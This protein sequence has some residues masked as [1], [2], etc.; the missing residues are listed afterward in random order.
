MIKRRAIS[1][2]QKQVRRQAMIDEAW[3]LF[4][5]QRYETINMIDV[6]QRVGLAKGTMYLYFKTKEHLFL[7]VLEQQF[8]AWFDE[9][10]ARLA[11]P[12]VDLERLIVDSLAERPA[13]A[14]L[15]AIAHTILEHNIDYDTTRR[16]KQVLMERVLHTGKLLEARFHFLDDGAAFL[17]RAYTLVIGIENVARPAAIVADVLEQET[18]LAALFKV[19]FINELTYMI[20]ILIKGGQQS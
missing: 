8:V 5:N 17:M 2:E 9:V 7:E 15:F 1:D 16:Y 4:Q 12:E 18:E 13:L 11:Q 19:D 3:R 14:R 6:A 10:D 20:R